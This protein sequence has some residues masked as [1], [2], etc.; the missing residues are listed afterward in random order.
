VVVAAAARAWCWAPVVAGVRCRRRRWTS[1]G[2]FWSVLAVGGSARAESRAPRHP[3]A[4]VENGRIRGDLGVGHVIWYDATM[5]TIQ[6]RNVPDQVHRT[7]RARAA[8][9]GVSLSDYA[10]GELERAA[11]RPPIADLLVR[12]SERAGGA[13]GEAIVAAVRAGRDRS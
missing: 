1:L 2:A 4:T 6:V 9:S 8:T 10:L 13:S 5:K 11:R 12:A 3:Q 7:L